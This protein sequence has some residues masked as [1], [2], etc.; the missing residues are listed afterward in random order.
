MLGGG[1]VR[2]M[3]QGSWSGFSKVD[4]AQDPATFV[5]YLDMVTPLKFTQAYK[6]LG[7]SLLRAQAGY[8]ILDVGCGTGEDVR[9]LAEI[10]GDGGSVVGLDNSEVMITEARTRTEG[11]NSRVQYH[12]GDAH[13]LDFGDSTFDGCRSDRTFQ[14]LDDPSR[15]L[16]EMIRVA[17]AGAYVVI[18]EPDWGT[19][20]INHPDRGLTRKIVNFKCET[21]RNGWIGRQLFGLFTVSGLADV[22]VVPVTFV[23]TDYDL[24]NQVLELQEN[25]KRA[26]QEGAISLDESARWLAQLGEVNEAGRFSSAVTGFVVAGRKPR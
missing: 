4:D 14:H 10:V 13:C 7:F 11:L 20:V 6:R 2:N 16:T 19:L 5:R 1:G 9:A 22:E 26:Q 12:L 17:K 24:T 23:A 3:E 25:A 15:A 8:R 18:S 21:A